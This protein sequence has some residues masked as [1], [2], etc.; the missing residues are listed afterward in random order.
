MS[1]RV[2]LAAYPT[3]YTALANSAL[4]LS[5]RGENEEA[6]PTGS[7]HARRPGPAAAVG[8]LG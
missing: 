2:W 6:L 4:L 1:Y 3:D 7:R 8:N 5:Q